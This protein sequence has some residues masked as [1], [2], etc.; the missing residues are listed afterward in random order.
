[1][2][3]HDEHSR[4]SRHVPDPRH[5]RQRTTLHVRTGGQ[6]PAVLLLH[7]YGETG[8]MWVPLATD[9]ASDHFVIVPDLRAWGA[10]PSPRAAMTEKTQGQDMAGLLDALGIAAVD[11]VTHDIGNMVGFAFAAQHRDRVHSF[12]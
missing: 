1:M 4:V 12:V 6:G 10:P 11:L 8:D 2:T 3:Q 7:G 9:L 5:S